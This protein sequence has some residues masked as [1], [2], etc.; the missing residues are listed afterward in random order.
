MADVAHHV[1]MDEGLVNAAIFSDP[2]IYRQEQ[3]KIF[4]RSWLFLAHE[5]QIP[6]PG[7]F[8]TTWMG[9]DPIL[10]V[11]KRDG[12]VGAYLNAC[13]HRGMKVCRADSG[14]AK[15]FTCTYH[16]WA[17]GMDGSLVNV[18]GLE[19][20]YFNELDTSKNGLVPVTQLDHYKGLYFGNWDPT[21]PS[22]Q[23]YL[24]DSTKFL[25]V[26]IDRR[27]GG[28]EVLPG[29]HKWSF[30]GNWK[31]AAEQ[32]A[33]DA[34]HGQM[35]HASAAAAMFEVNPPSADEGA[36]NP[37][38]N[39][40]GYQYSD[41]WGHG[42]GFSFDPR[43][44]LFPVFFASEVLTN[45]YRSTHAEQIER[46]GAPFGY[47]TSHNNIF[48]NL[49]Y[50]MPQNSLRVW[51]P[52]GPNAFEV[53]ALTL[54]DKAAPPEVKEAQ[55]IQSQLTFSAAGLYEQDDGENWS[56]IGENLGHGGTVIN[57]LKLNYQ[58]GIG[59]HGPS[60]DYPGTIG[61]VLVGE[62]PQRAFYRRWVEM[63]ESDQWPIP[64][65]DCAPTPLAAGQQ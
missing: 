49:S 39:V 11:R 25:D 24:G 59:H 33:G 31:L 64:E 16:G 58:M 57:S 53:W 14:N 50:L 15:A 45:Y 17:Y 41:Q 20:G 48:P 30:I 4:A 10:V 2:A 6:K 43:G 60:E 27:E 46:L 65:G 34:Y 8:F 19:D 51:H 44:Q 52:R 23:E 13:R 12:T 37:F 7:D 5:T 9:G 29:I 36:G 18:P 26:M 3:E 38:G 55:R 62:E 22:L 32:F 47:H 56:Q 1:D 21:A 35:S 40:V 54:V 42:T 28:V 63:M 61:N